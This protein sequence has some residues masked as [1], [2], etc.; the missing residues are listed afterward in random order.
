M[1]N[2]RLIHIYIYIASSLCSLYTINVIC[3]HT[4][5]HIHIYKRHVRFRYFGKLP[6]FMCVC[7]GNDLAR[8]EL[9]ARISLYTDFCLYSHGRVKCTRVVIYVKGARKRSRLQIRFT[10]VGVYGTSVCSYTYYYVAPIN[11]A[12]LNYRRNTAPR[13]AHSIHAVYAVVAFC[14][15]NVS[16][17]KQFPNVCRTRL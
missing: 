11:I 14:S 10:R 3:T 5:T 1:Y 13:L 8:R 12:S 9:A 4:Y 15:Q 7:V 2:I 16:F 6:K 17:A